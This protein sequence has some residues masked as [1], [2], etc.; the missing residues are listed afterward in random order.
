MK[1][2]LGYNLKI[3]FV[4]GESLLGEFVQVRGGGVGVSKFSAGGWTPP[5]HIRENIAIILLSYF[6]FLRKIKWQ[7]F[8][9]DTKYPSLYVT[10]S[11]NKYNKLFV[12][13]KLKVK[14]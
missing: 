2:W 6:F 4:G 3:V 8:Q 12:Q 7:N 5:S 13:L 9:N 14:F 10:C 11:F 1:F